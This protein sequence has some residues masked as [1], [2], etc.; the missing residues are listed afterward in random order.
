MVVHR[1]RTVPDGKA[2]SVFAPGELAEALLEMRRVVCGSTLMKKISTVKEPVPPQ[3]EWRGIDTAPKD[4][5]PVWL[6]LVDGG[7]YIGVYEQTWDWAR[8]RINRQWTSVYGAPA[9][10]VG[11]THWMPIP[12][13]PNAAP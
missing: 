9:P 2:A 4:G 10:G 12:K 3:N 7:V 5:T 1:C 8:F 6:A 11:I 13:H